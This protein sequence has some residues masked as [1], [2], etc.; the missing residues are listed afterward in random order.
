MELRT[1]W[2]SMDTMCHRSVKKRTPSS[3]LSKNWRKFLEK[4]YKLSIR[5]FDY[6]VYNR[7]PLGPKKFIFM[8]K[9]YEYL[10]NLYRFFPNST[11]VG[12]M[13]RITV[14]KLEIHG[15]VELV[16]K[17]FL[18]ILEFVRDFWSDCSGSDCNVTDWPYRE[19]DFIEKVK[20]DAD[21]LNQA[22]RLDKKF[23]KKPIS[24]EFSTNWNYEIFTFKH[25]SNGV[26]EK[27]IETQIYYDDSLWTPVKRIPLP[28]K[29][30]RFEVCKI[31][32]YMKNRFE[33]TSVIKV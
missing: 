23:L 27:E 4:K 26:S 30:V 1:I 28:K 32:I 10:I 9:C 20:N 22:R 29:L 8:K 21:H 5:D 17:S 6:I 33:I 11:K 18:R 13:V 16:H 12:D 24:T 31:W 14:G 7:L 19:V 2:I 15:L 25:I 3:R